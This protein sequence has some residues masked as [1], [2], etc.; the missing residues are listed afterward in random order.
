MR[1]V[2]EFGGDD[3]RSMAVNNSPLRSAPWQHPGMPSIF[4]EVL[5]GLRPGEVVFQDE[6]T[7]AFLDAEPVV[8]GHA[9]V[10]SKLAV[11]RIYELPPRDYQSV[12]ATV[13]LLAPV[14][15]AVTSTR[16][17]VVLASGFDVP[18]AHVH[19]M[20]ADAREQV[21][22]RSGATLPIT[23]DELAG[24][25]ARVRMELQRAEIEPPG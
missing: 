2:D 17:V 8:V 9:L 3:A 1:L 15:Q 10:V 12:W 18:H 22:G 13:R 25:A 11:D 21:F 24:L 16:R 23:K 19:L 20:P 6:R 5:N 14:L 7:F 4:D